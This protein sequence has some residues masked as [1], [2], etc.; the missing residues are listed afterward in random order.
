MEA[1]FVGAFSMGERFWSS[2]LV[3]VTQ[4]FMDI[5]AIY[6]AM[7]NEDGDVLE[8]LIEPIQ[9]YRGMKNEI[10]PVIPPIPGYKPQ[11]E[12]MDDWNVW[13]SYPKAWEEPVQKKNTIGDF[14]NSYYDQIQNPNPTLG[15]A[16]SLFSQ[17]S[18]PGGAVGAGAIALSNTSKAGG[19]GTVGGALAKGFEGAKKWMGKEG[20][21]KFEISDE[22]AKLKSLPKALQ[23]ARLGD[24]IDHPELFKNYPELSEMT[25]QK[26]LPMLNNADKGGES[27]VGGIRAAGNR[28]D[29][30]ILS[31]ILHEIQHKIQEKEGFEGGLPSNVE[32]YWK[33]AGEVEG[34]NVQHRMDW[35][36]EMRRER[37]FTET[38]DV[39][40]EEQLFRKRM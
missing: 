24:V 37:P 28:P 34:R 20:L 26:M 9:K 2:L 17:Y 4:D 22:F 7:N 13:D 19:L 39:P 15:D 14:V 5:Q 32:D 18:M 31:S 23:E 30:D 38:F 6:D 12:K 8:T 29:K 16:A 1:T 36:D 33:G 21:Q 40:L 35:T 25:V 10:T 3:R 27:F 11:P